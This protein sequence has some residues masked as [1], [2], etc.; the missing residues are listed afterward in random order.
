MGGFG[1]SNYLMQR[2]KSHFPKIQ[3]LQP[4]DAWAAIVKYVPPVFNFLFGLSNVVRRGA[5]LSK[6]PSQVAVVST[7]ATR[8]YGT[9][10][11]SP[12]QEPR[13][14]GQQAFLDR[15][16]NRRVTIVGFSFQ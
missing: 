7:C 1:S 2:V 12:F 6:L 11:E 9:R 10:C 14:A 5:V 3:V 8:H 15:D 4:S 13:D 16:C